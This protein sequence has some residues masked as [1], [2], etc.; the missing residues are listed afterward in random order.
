M[1]S[2]RQSLRDGIRKI[3]GRKVK[4]LRRRGYLRA[5][6]YGKGFESISVKLLQK[7]AEKLFFEVGTTGLF[8][9]KLADKSIPVLFKNPQYHPVSDVLIH[10]DLYKVDLS[11]KIIAEIPIVLVGEA[12]IVKAGNVL[13]SVMDNVEVEALPADLPEKIEI[14]ISV[15]EEISSVITV[16]D[17]KVDKSKVEL[18]TELN[19]V[20]AKIEEPREEEPEPEPVEEVMEGEEGVEKKEGEE[21]KEKKEGEKE[22][23][24]EGGEENKDG[25]GKKEEKTSLS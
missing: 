12:P 22:D 8:D 10:V 11:E 13:V 4:Q 24:K 18:K 9:L 17:L 5:S 1:T 23:K 6:V 21:G 14:D 19:Q 16:S 15:M 3:L 2:K 7:D 20:I 25:G